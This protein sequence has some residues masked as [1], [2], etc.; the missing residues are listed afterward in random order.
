MNQLHAQIQASTVAEIVKAFEAEGEEAMWE[1]IKNGSNF[2]EVLSEA[3]RQLH[4]TEDFIGALGAR[5]DTISERKARLRE[6]A[7][8]LRTLLHSVLLTS[9]V[10]KA[11][12]P[13][14]TISVTAVPVGVKILDESQLPESFTRIKREADKTAIKEALKRGEVVPGA[15]LTNGGETITIRSK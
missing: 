4:D 14:A 6:R 11:E 9:G 13:E 2:S 12:L 5:E 1:A 10:R 15:T 7:N 3:L 8:R